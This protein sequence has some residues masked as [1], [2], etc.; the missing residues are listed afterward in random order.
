[1][2]ISKEIKVALLGV[3][4]AVALFFGYKFLRGS[5]LFSKTRTFYAVYESVDGLTVSNPVV[6]NG[7][8]VGI[9][10]E[11]VLI[12]EQK[13]KI[14]IKMDINKDIDVGDST[15]ASLE[16]SSILGGKSITLIMGRNTRRYDGD[17]TLISHIEVGLTTLLAA[18]AMPLAGKIDTAIANINAFFDAEANKSMHATLANTEASTEALKKIL[19]MN[20]RNLSVI[21]GNL[22]ELSGSL[23]GT[24]QRF[25]YLADNLNS[26]TDTLKTT[27][28]NQAVRNMNATIMEA[29][30][31][32]KRFNDKTGTIGKLM[33]DDSLYNNLNNTARDMDALMIDLKE[34]PKRYV[35]FSL[36]GRKETPIVVKEKTKK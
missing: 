32:V 14:C 4:A 9:V 28:I 34:N 25:N 11:V 12:P 10:Q 18:R 30:T 1:M 29:Q 13:N 20:Q 17:D 36:F 24:Q 35:H 31:A 16:S 3:V 6:L 33:N 27:Q 2:R 15:V 8:K 22:S 5:D 21:T 19:E 7:V 23:K 26:I